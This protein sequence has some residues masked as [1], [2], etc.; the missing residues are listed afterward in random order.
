MAQSEFEE[1]VSRYERGEINKNQAVE[2]VS[3]FG[4]SIEKTL[5]LSNLNNSIKK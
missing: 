2:E 3:K 1:I 4:D 5:F